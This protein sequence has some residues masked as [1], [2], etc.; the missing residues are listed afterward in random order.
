[1]PWALSSAHRPL[2]MVH[3]HKGHDRTM[4]GM[5]LVLQSHQMFY[6]FYP[7]CTFVEVPNL[8]LLGMYG[9]PFYHRDDSYVS[10]KSSITSGTAGNA[11]HKMR[12][13]YCLLFFDCGARFVWISMRNVSTCQTWFLLWSKRILLVSRYPSWGFKW[14]V[15]VTTFVWYLYLMATICCVQVS[16]QSTYCR[17]QVDL[18]GCDKAFDKVIH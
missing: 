18:I 13:L 17:M 12:L 15:K 3:V 8:N 10:G 1:M 5:K 6:L 9:Q 4:H 16:E 11:I 14:T 2:C 7:W